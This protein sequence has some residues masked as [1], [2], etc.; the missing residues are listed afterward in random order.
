MDNLLTSEGGERSLAVRLHL[1][2]ANGVPRGQTVTAAP[3]AA[4][5]LQAPTVDREPGDVVPVRSGVAVVLPILESHVTTVNLGWS[6][7]HAATRLAKL[8][9]QHLSGGDVLARSRAL[10]LRFEPRNPH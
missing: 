9:Q 10:P 6:L 1:N 7:T 4:L 2:H 3:L 8:S 5:S